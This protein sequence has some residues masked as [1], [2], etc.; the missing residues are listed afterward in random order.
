MVTGEGRVKVLDFGLAKLLEPAERRATPTTLTRA[1]DRRRARWSAP[2][3]TCRPNRP[4]GGSSTRVG[5]LQL[6]CGALRDG[7]R[8]AAVRGRLARCRSSR[9]S[10][11][12]TRAAVH[13][14]RRSARRRNER[15]CAACAR[16]R[17]AASDDGGSEGSAEDLAAD[18]VVAPAVA[19]QSGQRNPLER[20][21]VCGNRAGGDGWLWPLCC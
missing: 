11:T 8:P 5:H 7:D 20:V 10:S 21:P 14:S 19:A 2:P 18:S 15:S 12:R 1:A 16:I 13:E 9:R 6:R 17:P 3:P 4:K